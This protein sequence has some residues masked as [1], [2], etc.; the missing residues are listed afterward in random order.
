MR[1]A[2]RMPLMTRDGNDEAPI[3]PGARWNIDPCEAAPP[4]KLWR[5]MTPWKPLPRLTPMTSTRSP[6]ANTPVTSTWSPAFIGSAPLA[7]V[8][9]R[10]TRVGGTP[11]FW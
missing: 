11:A 7:S 3:E 1:P 8:T 5:F 4:E 6:S 2:A 9:S 10:R